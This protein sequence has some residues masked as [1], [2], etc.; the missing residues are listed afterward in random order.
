MTTLTCEIDASAQSPLPLRD[1]Q[2]PQAK[3]NP[4]ILT[5]FS[6]ILM[7]RYAWQSDPRQ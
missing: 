7:P 3:I 2:C 6:P 4:A 5:G 1:L